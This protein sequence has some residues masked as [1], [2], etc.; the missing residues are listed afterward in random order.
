MGECRTPGYTVW[1]S[2][3]GLGPPRVQAGPLEW[4]S[5][6]LYGVQAAHNG[7]QGLRTEH[8]RALNRTQAGVRCR[9]VSGPSLMG[10]GLVRRYSYSPLRQRPD[11]TMWHTARGLSQRAELSM[12]PLGYVRHCIH[13]R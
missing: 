11:A 7:S 2:K 10:S 13:Y 12:T 8:T 5:D 3:V 4:D 9:H 6:P 1:T